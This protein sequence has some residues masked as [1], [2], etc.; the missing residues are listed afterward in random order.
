MTH[1]L[2]FVSVIGLFW[3]SRAPKH[4]RS[5][6]A[7]SILTLAPLM[8]VLVLALTGCGG[9]HPV[10]PLG[11]IIRHDHTAAMWIQNAPICSG[12]PPVCVPGGMSYIPESWSVTV[13]DAHNPKWEGTVNVDSAVYAA[14]DRPKWW[15]TCY[16]QADVR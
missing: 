10:P 13:R 15:P 4:S 12:S 7:A 16:E 6:T 5:S 2:L 1:L 8:A 9:P 14:C 3:L 11:P